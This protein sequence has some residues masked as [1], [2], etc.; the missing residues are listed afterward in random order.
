VEAETGEDCLGT[1]VGQQAMAVENR[2]GTVAAAWEARVVMVGVVMEVAE[3]MAGA[4]E[5]A[6]VV[7]VVVEGEEQAAVVRVVEEAKAAGGMVK[8]EQ[9]VEVT[10]PEMGAVAQEEEVLEEEAVKAVA[11][12]AVVAGMGVQV[13]ATREGVVM[14]VVRRVEEGMV[15]ATKVVVVASGSCSRLRNDHRFRLRSPSRA[16]LPPCLA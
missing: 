12:K 5:M 15:V 7:R 1:A 2:G 16:S 10:E 6:A 8:V 13:E 4:E 3:E 14:V 11:V 9:R